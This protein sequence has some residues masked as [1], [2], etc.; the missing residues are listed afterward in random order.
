MTELLALLADGLERL[1]VPVANLAGFLDDDTPAF[2]LLPALFGVLTVGLR[3]LSELLGLLP[4][5]LRTRFRF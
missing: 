1:T 4:V 3:V 5:F 2:G